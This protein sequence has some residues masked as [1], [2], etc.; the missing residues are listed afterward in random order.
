VQPE[1]F[2]VQLPH[3]AVA[4][5]VS[6]VPVR[7]ERRIAILVDIPGAPCPATVA[8]RI[9]D[10]IEV[11]PDHQLIVQDRHCLCRAGRVAPQTHAA[12]IV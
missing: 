11:S 4:A 12:Q 8:A 10:L 9:R 7:V 3:Q 1:S 5:R 6:R 2:D